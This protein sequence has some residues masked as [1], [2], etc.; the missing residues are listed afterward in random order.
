MKFTNIC[1]FGDSVTWGAWLKTRVGWVHLLRD[2]L[3]L[4][5]D[6]DYAVYDLGI[7]GNTSQDLLHRFT[8]E[9]T[10]RP[11]GIVI[12]VIGINDSLYRHK[13]GNFNVSPVISRENLLK[14][15]QQARLMT[16]RIVLV[17]LVKGDDVLTNPLP[18][19]STGK[20]YSKTN[21]KLYDQIIRE[22]AQDEQL[23][24]VDVYD[25]LDDSDF[26]DGLHPNAKGH[27]KIYGEVREGLEKMLASIR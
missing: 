12:I 18:V 5:F 25:K 11:P 9:I 1:V 16:N 24:F 22:V 13:P 19:S 14:L 8:A 23:I 21:A 20:S 3:E 7:D 6:H 15:I 10:A 26:I 27:E 4:E 2:A 17:G